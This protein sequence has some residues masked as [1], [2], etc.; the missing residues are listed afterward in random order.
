[1]LIGALRR[2]FLRRALKARIDTQ[3]SVAR[4]FPN[5]THKRC[6][7]TY[8]MYL[9]AGLLGAWRGSIRNRYGFLNHPPPPTYSYR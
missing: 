5:N 6:D 9:R 7:A 3:R 1:M 2:P 4:I 8:P